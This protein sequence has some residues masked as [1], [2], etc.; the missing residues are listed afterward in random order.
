M[1]PK[2][3]CKYVVCGRVFD[4]VPMGDSTNEELGRDIWPKR[5]KLL[6]RLASEAFN[7]SKED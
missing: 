1:T 5:Y 3:F 7:E 6:E 4:D 2:E